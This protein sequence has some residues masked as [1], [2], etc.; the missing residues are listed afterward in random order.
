MKNIKKPA[1]DCYLSYQ[2]KFFFFYFSLVF[3]PKITLYLDMILRI[4]TNG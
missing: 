2:F 1:Y 4:I 3:L